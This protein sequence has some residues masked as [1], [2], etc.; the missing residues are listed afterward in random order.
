MLLA[1]FRKDK[2]GFAKEDAEVLSALSAIE[3]SLTSHELVS[4]R[5]R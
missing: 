5:L 4:A 1:S 3:P 2:V